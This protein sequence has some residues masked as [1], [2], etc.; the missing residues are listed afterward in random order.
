[1]G[2]IVAQAAHELNNVMAI[3]EQ[4]AG[5]LQDLMAQ[6]SVLAPEK[7]GQI[8][9]EIALQGRRGVDILRAVRTFAHSTD[10]DHTTFDVIETLANLCLLARRSA[11]LKGARIVV[12]PADPSPRLQGSPF[13]FQQ[14]LYLVLESCLE[15]AGESDTLVI[16]AREQDGH[17][18]VEVEGCR[19]GSPNRPQKEQ[20][21]LLLRS[22]RGQV[23]WPDLEGRAHIELEFGT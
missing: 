13:R 22:Q 5:L 7:L 9:D 19:P 10:S 4:N 16:L 17:V 8:A 15:A 23:R 12:E 2:R 1:M 6:G 3:V 20:I 14:A 11:D 18:L 21:E